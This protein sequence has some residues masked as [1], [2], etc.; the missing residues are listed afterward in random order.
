MPPIWFSSG[1]FNNSLAASILARGAELPSRDKSEERAPKKFSLLL[2]LLLLLSQPSISNSFSTI[3][4]MWSSH[5]QRIQNASSCYHS[6]M[7]PCRNRNVHGQEVGHPSPRESGFLQRRIGTMEIPPRDSR[8]QQK[9][10]AENQIQQRLR[11]KKVPTEK[12][13]GRQHQVTRSGFTYQEVVSA[14]RTSEPVSV[15][16]EI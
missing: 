5:R 1:R 9:I 11:W 6:A 10:D 2:W 8:G 14:E 13:A 16:A 12:D 15:H 7:Y 3:R 4:N